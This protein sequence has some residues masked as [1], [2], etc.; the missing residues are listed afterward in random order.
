MEA[1]IKKNQLSAKKVQED[2]SQIEEYNQYK[3]L[4]AMRQLFL[5]PQENLT[6]EEGK[7]FT[8]IA[9]KFTL[10]KI[11]ALMSQKK[12]IIQNSLDNLA[13]Y[14]RK[15]HILLSDKKSLEEMLLKH[16]SSILIQNIEQMK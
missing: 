14:K 5:T 4:F 10:V 1:E 16:P 13:D 9:K 7:I 8:E 15:I 12:F 2:L 11:E 6:Q 3:K